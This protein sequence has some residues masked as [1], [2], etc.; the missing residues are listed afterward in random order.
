MHTSPSF[1]HVE[2]H[3]IT[4]LTGARGCIALNDVAYQAICLG[5][6]VQDRRH[7]TG[8]VGD[9]KARNGHR[10]CTLCKKDFRGSLLKAQP[11]EVPNMRDEPPAP[12]GS[13]TTAAVAP[14]ETHVVH[15]TVVGEAEKASQ[16]VR[17]ALYRRWS[18]LHTRMHGAQR[19]RSGPLQIGGTVVQPQ[20]PHP[21]SRRCRHW[22]RGAQC[23]FTKKVTHPKLTVE[24]SV[25]PVLWDFLQ[26]TG[27]LYEKCRRC[28]VSNPRKPK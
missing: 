25:K 1:K 20:K 18:Y 7:L 16:E 14:Q 17:E 27:G 21:H 12:S 13:A 5:A 8:Q 15:A 22:P 2:L 28:A 10:I 19:T 6:R 11:S 4:K 24:S 26:D 9:W 23:T 3:K